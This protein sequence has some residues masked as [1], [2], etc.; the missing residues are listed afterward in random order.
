MPYIKEQD[1]EAAVHREEDMATLQRVDCEVIQRQ[2]IRAGL[3]DTVVL[4]GGTA[5][6]AGLSG[7]VHKLTWQFYELDGTVR[8]PAEYT[9]SSTEYF[10]LGVGAPGKRRQ[11]FYTDTEPF[12]KHSLHDTLTG[13][14][15]P[16]G[17]THDYSAFF[18]YCRQHPD[19]KIVLHFGGP[20]FLL[21]QLEAEPDIRER[22][23]LIGAMLLSFDGEANLLGRNFNEAVV[24]QLTEEVFGDDGG[25]IHSSFPT[26]DIIFVP[27]ETCKHQTFLFPPFEKEI[28]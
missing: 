25:K 28:D 21:K 5:E 12:L 17:E 19:A 22:V 23:I 13:R 15:K 6:A 20:V 3:G 1:F 27:T 14:T 10:H 4:K 18:K 9:Q 8:S 2:L 11:K 26:A 16:D 7:N 24:P